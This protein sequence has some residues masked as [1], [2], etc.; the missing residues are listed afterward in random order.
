MSKKKTAPGARFLA[1]TTFVIGAGVMAVELTASRLL[2]PY[3]GASMFVWT[4]LI[5]TVLLALAVGYW[6]GGSLAG[7]GHDAGSGGFLL[8]STGVLLLGGLGVMR[9]VAV[10]ISGLLVGF[11]PPSIELFLGLIAPTIVG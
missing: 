4:S 1:F 8:C 10:G 11:S 6:F 9:S 7:K 5:V 2:A 3:F